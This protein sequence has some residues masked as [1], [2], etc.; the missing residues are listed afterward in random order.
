MN[1]STEEFKIALLQ[2]IYENTKVQR[3]S[4]VQISIRCPICG[5][6]KKDKS[7]KRFG[8][9]IDVHNDDVPVLYNCFN[10]NEGGLLTPSILRSLDIYDLDVITGLR[11]YNNKMSRENNKYNVKNEKLNIDV[12]TVDETDNKVIS[13]KEYIESRIGR[14]FSFDELYALKTIFSL[15]ETLVSN[16]ISK[17]TCNR[18]KA[19]DLDEKYVGFLNITNEMINFRQVMK[20]KYSRY[21]KYLIDNFRGNQLKFYVMPTEVDIMSREPI[22]INL[23]EGVFDIIGIRYNVHNDSLKHAI[24]AAVC[25]SNYRSVIEY[26]IREG[27]VGDDVTLNIFRDDDQYLKQYKDLRDEYGIWFGEFN[28][29]SNTIDKDFGVHADKIDMIRNRL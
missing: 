9:K 15:G 17:V 7:K 24:Y 22:T 8:I 27:V 18:E 2:S 11:A 26:F 12:P 20:S 13:K 25:G 3:L 29:Y 10:C 16:N 21:E 14:K 28:V 6:S 23:A 5:D 19:I 4:D 1:F